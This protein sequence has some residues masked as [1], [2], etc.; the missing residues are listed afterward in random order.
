[1]EPVTETITVQISMRRGMGP[2]LVL[3]NHARVLLGLDIWVPSWAFR[4][5]KPVSRPAK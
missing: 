2:L 1:M 3:V 5:G 4:I